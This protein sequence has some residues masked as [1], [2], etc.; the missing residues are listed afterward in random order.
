M[1]VENVI[2]KNLFHEPEKQQ[3][4]KKR[5]TNKDNLSSEHP[6]DAG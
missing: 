3:H 1:R 4:L 5:K 6:N 2:A